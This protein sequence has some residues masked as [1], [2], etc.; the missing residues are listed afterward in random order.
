MVEIIH[1]ACRA[2]AGSV[3]LLGRAPLPRDPRLL[4]RVGIQSQAGAQVHGPT[5][6]DAFVAITG[7]GCR[8]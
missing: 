5:L 3:E 6:E 1:G 4:A 7:K 8:S 2:G